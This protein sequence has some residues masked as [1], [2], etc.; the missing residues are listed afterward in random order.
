A[1]SIGEVERG[2]RALGTARGSGSRATR[3][4]L[5]VDLFSALTPI[6]A[7]YVAKN[8]IREMRTGVAEGVVVDGLALLAGGQR[9][10]IARAHQLEGDLAEV[11]AAVVAH[12]G[13]PPPASTLAYFRPLRPIP[14][15]T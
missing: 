8:L 10:A 1:L 2:V 12:R 9:A 5:L 7:K 15:R 13:G 4:R 6:E 11:A 3:E 14:A